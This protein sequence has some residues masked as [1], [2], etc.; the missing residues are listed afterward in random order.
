MTEQEQY[1]A[2]YPEAWKPEPGDKIAGKVI[3]VTQSPDFGY[4]PYPIVTLNVDGTER[5]VH[6]FHH[7]LRTEL[8]RRRP[9][10]G[11]DLEIVYQGQR[12]PKSGTN[13]PFHAYRVQGGQEREFNWDAELPEGEREALGASASPPIAPAPVPSFQ[14]PA[15]PQETPKPAGG[16]FGDEVPF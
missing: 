5:A 8:A 15:Q 3:G 7:V 13:N 4:G 6:A 11:D 1:E 16:Q 14:A 12:K 9:R 2:D 10:V